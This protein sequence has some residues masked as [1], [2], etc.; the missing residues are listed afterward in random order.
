M[1]AE[2]MKLDLNRVHKDYYSAKNDPSLR[3]YEL[4]DY[5]TLSGVGAPESDLFQQ[6]IEAIYGVAYTIKKFCK[7]EGQDFVVPKLEAFWWVEAGREFAQTPREEWYWKLLIRMPEFV[8]TAQVEEAIQ[9]VIEKK[10]IS[11]ANEVNH[12]QITEGKCVQ[13]LHIGSYEEEK[14]TIDKIFAYMNEQGYQMN[15]QH[16]E[17]YISDPR[18]TAIEKLKTVI[19]YAVK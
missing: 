8:N 3:E 15:G 14:S 5:L 1:I 11:L 19:R 9:Q 6:S 7:V 10:N 13:A 4:I 18:K 12:E 16:H 2:K 17:I